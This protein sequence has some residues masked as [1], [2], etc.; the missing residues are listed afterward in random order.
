MAGAATD[1]SPYAIIPSFT[2]KYELNLDTPL[3]PGTYTAISKVSLGDG[4]VLDTKTTSFEVPANY[5]PP[6]QAASVKLTAR[7]SAVLASPDGRVTIEFPAGAVF[8]DTDVSIKPLAKDQAPAPSTGMAPASTFFTVG[9]ING[10]LAKDATLIVKYSSA[11]LE[12]ARSD[13]SKLVLARYDDADNKWTILPTTLD[14]SALTLSTTTNRF[15][16]LGVMVSSGGNTQGSTQG[17]AGSTA[18][19]GSKPGIGLDPTIVFVALGLMIVFVGIHR[20]RKH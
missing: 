9:G 5:I 16:T 17:S 11:D 15:G 14:K 8:S 12:A 19:G 13:V 6:I 7:S 4:T 3:P 20:A 2:V 1:P 18:A 10:L